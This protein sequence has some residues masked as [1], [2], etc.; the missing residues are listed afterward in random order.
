MILEPPRVSY[1][2]ICNLLI[3]PVR[4]P[5]EPIRNKVETIQYFTISALC[6]MK[7]EPPSFF[8]LAW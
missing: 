7:R 5:V 1:V 6:A 3:D 2:S 4:N 8:F